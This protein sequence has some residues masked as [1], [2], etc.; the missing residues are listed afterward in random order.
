MELPQQEP[1]NKNTNYVFA[2]VT[3]IEGNIFSNQTGYFPMPVTGKCIT[4]WC[5]MCFMQ[6]TSKEYTSKAEQHQSYK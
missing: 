5:F 1:G 4:L 3:Q 2:A 6:I